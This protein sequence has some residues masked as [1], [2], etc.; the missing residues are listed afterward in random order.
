M[1]KD[2]IVADIEGY[3]TDIN[4]RVITMVDTLGFNDIK[5]F[6]ADVFR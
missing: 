6:D 4:G 3:T 5:W 2:L 1:Y